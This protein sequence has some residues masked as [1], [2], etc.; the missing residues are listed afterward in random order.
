[1]VNSKQMF[2]GRVIITYQKNG[3]NKPTV[4]YL[5]SPQINFLILLALSAERPHEDASSWFW[6]ERGMKSRGGKAKALPR[7]G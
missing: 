4:C 2:W 6:W 5:E 1:M 7:G 3:C